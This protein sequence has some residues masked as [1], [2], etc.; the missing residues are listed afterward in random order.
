MLRTAVGVLPPTALLAAACAGGDAPTRSEIAATSRGRM[1]SASR[2]SRTARRALLAAT[3]S[4]MG[5]G[6]AAADPPGEQREP[7]NLGVMSLESLG[8]STHRETFSMTDYTPDPIE[9]FNRGSLA[10]TR[11]II[12]W[13]VRPL[14]KGWRAITPAAVRGSLENFYYNLGY[15]GRL[16]SL[17]L[18]AEAIDAG[19]ETGHFLVNST[20]GVAGLFDPASHLGIPTRREDVGLAFARW[21]S[22]PGF[23]FF[24]PF[25]G[26]SSGRD[27][28]GRIFDTALH[29]TTYLPG[30]G[31]FFN[32]NAFSGRIDGYE[33]LVESYADLY[34]PVRALWSIQRQA[35]VER[36]AITPE[37]Y[38]RSNPDPS[39]GVLAFKPYDKGFVGDAYEGK[40]TVPATGRELPFSAWM[41]EGAAPVVVIL[42]G[43][44]AHRT[45]STPV[46][47]AEM[48]FEA[49]YS[50]VVVSSPFH[51]EFAFNGLSAPY[52]GYTP[53]DVTDLEVVFELIRDELDD[54]FG[55]RV[56]S[57]TLLGYSLGAIETLFL[58]TRQ[59]ELPRTGV[60][61]DRFV[62]VNPPVDLGYSARQFDAF[63]DLPLEWPEAE[64]SERVKRAILK[65]FVVLRDGPGDKPLPFD[66]EESRFLIG[67][68]GR[69]MISDLMEAIEKHT[70]QRL[71]SAAQPRGPLQRRVHESSFERYVAEILAPHLREK[72]AADRETLTR[73]ASLTALAS[74]LAGMSEVR[75]FTNAN[76]FIVSD[77]GRDWLRQT[78]GNRVTIFPDGGHLGNLAD[79]SV[80]QAILD[81]LA[82]SAQAAAR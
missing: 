48:A 5:A 1:R 66:R 17:L 12:H 39:I 67:L 68:M 65:A 2:F 50:A 11:P 24:L 9:G 37:D 23:Y 20:V 64:R 46:A 4:V 31:L 54:E 36:F 26:P 41:Q 69:T 62:A 58:A 63:F 42:P 79:P 61:F 72:H 7:D 25:F 45:S 77:Q 32:V 10:F 82:P 57:A 49:G 29:P 71:E 40:V 60:R 30:S 74:R 44:G 80:Q 75:V 34:L 15:P 56:T 47:L 8:S 21:G 16:V 81:A 27:A 14:A 28:L 38:A 55:P 13:G 59:A 3:L 70:G 18:Q 35:A 78:F 19:K 76:D 33:T 43:I 52:P 22:G 53:D 51:R 6:S 73:Q